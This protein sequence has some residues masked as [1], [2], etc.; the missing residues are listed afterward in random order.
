[1]APGLGACLAG[2]LEVLDAVLLQESGADDA[3]FSVR[4]VMARRAAMGVGGRLFGVRLA[5]R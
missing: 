3:A 2:G 4:A 5:R 1:M